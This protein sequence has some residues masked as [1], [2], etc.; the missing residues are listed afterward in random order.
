[1]KLARRLGFG[2]IE[3]NVDSLLVANI[4]NNNKEGSLMD[5]TLVN[6]ICSFI[7]LNW[8][9]VVRHIYCEANQCIDAL[10]NLKCSLNSEMCIF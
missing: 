1:L 4:I 2:A 9:V 3:V 5:R 6:K 8:E 10:A 7:A